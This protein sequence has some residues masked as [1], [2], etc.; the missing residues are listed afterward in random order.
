MSVSAYVGTDSLDPKKVMR[1]ID[2]PTRRAVIDAIG[3]NGPLQW[4]GLAEQVGEKTGALYHHLDVMEKLVVRDKE[5]RYVLTKLGADIYG[6]M[7]QD[8]VLSQKTVVRILERNKGGGTALEAFAPRVALG[9]MSS[10]R[11]AWT[12]SFVLI[13]SPSI[14]LLTYSKEAVWLFSVMPAGDYLTPGVSL[15]ASVV[16]VAGIP[17]AALRLGFRRQVKP[18]PLFVAA[19]LSLL[20]FVIFGAVERALG[21]TLSST[22]LTLVLVLL[23]AWMAGVV[24]AGA[25]VASGLR[26]ERTL[27]VSL[28]LVYLSVVLI[29]LNQSGLAP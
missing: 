7:S 13:F 21:A 20:P 29:L 19:V 28:V 10:S 25:S 8:A 4:K 11:K 27:L 15:A 16:V 9:R 18:G 3:K 12:A 26:I 23:Q 17:L 14:A 22:S 6:Q 24:G 1:I 5:G 2:H